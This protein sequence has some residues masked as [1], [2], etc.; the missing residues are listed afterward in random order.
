MEALRVYLL[1]IWM[2]YLLEF[3]KEYLL[4]EIGILVGL[5]EGKYGNIGCDGVGLNDG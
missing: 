2:E 5:N 4:D 3:E 1:V